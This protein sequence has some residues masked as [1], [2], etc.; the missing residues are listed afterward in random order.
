MDASGISE[1][2]RLDRLVGANWTACGGFGVPGPRPRASAPAPSANRYRCESR[3]QS[4]DRRVSTVAE[5]A[6]VH[7]AWESG[8][9]RQL[10]TELP[11]SSSLNPLPLA[12]AEIGRAAHSC[13]KPDVDRLR[14]PIPRRPLPVKAK[15]R[16]IGPLPRLLP[17][18]P[19]NPAL[20]LEP[21]P[22]QSRPSSNASPAGCGQSAAS[23][24]CKPLD[25]R[26]GPMPSPARVAPDGRQPAAAR[27][28]RLAPITLVP[29]H[30]KR[31]GGSASTLAAS[32]STRRNAWWNNRIPAIT[33]QIAL[34]P[35][36]PP[37]SQ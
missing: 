1:Q 14:S 31:S 37:R 9:A 25:T 2:S 3:S 20:E 5:T 34:G 6:R 8:A 11:R 18:P 17:R 32:G 26:P 29:E 23:P 10:E 15:H 27:L 7:P 22:C 13:L 36:R 30:Q 12:A 21:A 28:P 4:N 16:F 24:S 19:C 35:L 33:L